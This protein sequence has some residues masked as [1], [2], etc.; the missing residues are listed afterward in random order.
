MNALAIS[1]YA[2]Y[3]LSAFVLRT[4]IHLC[5]TGDTGFR[6]L[7]GRPG[8]APWWAGVL[9]VVALAIGLAAPIAGWAGLEPISLLDHGF[10]NLAGLTLASAG[11]ILTLIAQVHMGR[12]WRIGVD[13]DEHTELVTGG[14]F[15]F[16]RNPFFSATALAALGLALMVP[17]LVAAAGLVALIAALELQVRIVEEPYLRATHGQ[18]Y[19]DY[20]ARTGRF[21]PFVRPTNQPGDPQVTVTDRR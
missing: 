17:N 7:S 12:A 4:V 15:G 11:V 18:T 5:R 3:L 21:V 9:F 16:V 8:S 6:G 20:V 10:V 1:I 2:I 13:E 19:V 14:I